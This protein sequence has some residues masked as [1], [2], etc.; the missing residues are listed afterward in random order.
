MTDTLLGIDRSSGLEE[1]KLLHVVI[2]EHGGG[3][4][5]VEVG[6]VRAAS[7]DLVLGVNWTTQSQVW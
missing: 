7:H 6:V 5:G 4:L 1:V 3:Q 2:P